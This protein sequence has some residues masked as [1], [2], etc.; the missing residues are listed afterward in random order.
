MHALSI[1]NENKA[2]ILSLSITNLLKEKGISEN[3]LA[4][5]LNIPYNTIHRII[6]GATSD[7]RLSTLHQIATYF[8]VS[9]DSLVSE[10]VYYPTSR[11]DIPQEKTPLLS[12][13]MLED[14]NFHKKLNLLPHLKWIATP[15]MGSV[16]KENVIF[17]LEA[18][19]SMQSRFPLGTTF[20]INY[21]E[22][23]VDGDIVLVKFTKSNS[24][25]L[26]ELVTDPPQWQL[27][28]I[29]P[30]SQSIYFDENEHLIIG[31]VM[32]TLIQTRPS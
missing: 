7:P 28:P 24:S 12:W 16:K 2:E 17:A 21:N 8:K 5:E 15:P 26:R 30:G 20:I 6:T 29:T 22:K 25:S 11:E 1:E 4:K 27:V 18:T 19:K 31:V 32:L 23:P 13:D 9:I 3:T 10:E 14:F